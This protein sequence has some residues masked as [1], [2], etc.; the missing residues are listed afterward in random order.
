MHVPHPNVQPRAV[1]RIIA[2]GTATLAFFTSSLICTLESVPPTTHA[3]ARKDR[4][5]ANP[6]GQRDTEK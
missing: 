4:R 6:L 5:N 1:D 3:G 2:R